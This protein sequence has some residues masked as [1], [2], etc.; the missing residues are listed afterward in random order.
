VVALSE[1]D[2]SRVYF[3]LGLG[4]RAGCD[5]GDLAEVEQACTTIPDD[6]THGRVKQ[7]LDLCDAAWDKARLG[8]E[9]RFT[10]REIYQ[11]D[12]N[13]AILRESASD[14]RVWKEQYFNE[15][16]ELAQ[17]LWV[18]NYRMAGADRFRFTRAAGSFISCIPGNADTSVSSRRLEFSQLAGSFGF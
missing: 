2:K 6:Y 11:G 16:E 7:Q 5:A 12:L 10:T 1:L 3:H 8:G 9:G 15:V 13:R 18:P 17:L 14:D 4:C